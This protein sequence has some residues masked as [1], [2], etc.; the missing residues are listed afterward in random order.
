MLPNK[1]S[2]GN[3]GGF[4]YFIRYVTN[5]GFMLVDNG[6]R[7][8]NLLVHDKVFLEKCNELCDHIN[9]YFKKNLIVNHCIMKIY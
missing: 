1:D 9:I 3:E 2:Y 6:S 8:M 4:S 7:C 5:A